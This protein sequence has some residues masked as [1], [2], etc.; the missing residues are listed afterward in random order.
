VV[1]FAVVLVAVAAIYVFIL[2]GGPV[3]VGHWLGPIFA[4]R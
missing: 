1:E 2:A 4:P 3:A